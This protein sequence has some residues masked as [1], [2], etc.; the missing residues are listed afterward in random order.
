MNEDNNS[1]NEIPENVEILTTGI[2]ANESE[3]K[4][5]L[6]SV[7]NKLSGTVNTEDRIILNGSILKCLRSFNVYEQYIVFK[8][9][10]KELDILMQSKDDYVDVLI[11]NG[12]VIY[13]THNPDITYPVYNTIPLCPSLKDIKS[14]ILLILANIS[15]ETISHLEALKKFNI[16]EIYKYSLAV[17]M[18]RRLV[19]SDE[20]DNMQR[21]Q[22]TIELIDRVI[23]VLNSQEYWDI[24]FVTHP[25]SDVLSKITLAGYP[26]TELI[27]FN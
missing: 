21:I 12:F 16:D 13:E 20:A 4:T 2:F 27:N 24:S 10:L 15:N 7:I 3:E 14:S 18:R 5:E 22:D 25:N 11:T 17:D 19:F 23:K 26:V 8:N 6:N 1:N 9:R